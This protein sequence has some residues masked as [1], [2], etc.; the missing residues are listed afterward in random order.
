MR[1]LVLSERI[2]RNKIA[3]CVHL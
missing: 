2:E 1:T 3:N